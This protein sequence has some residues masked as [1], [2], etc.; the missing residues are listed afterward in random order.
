MSSFCLAAAQLDKSKYITIDEVKPGMDAYCLTVFEGTKI[1]KFGLEVLSVVHNFQ[2]GRDA[3]LVQGTDERFIHTG[4]VAGCSGS[5]VYIDGRLAGAL[6]FAWTYSKDPLYGVTPIE[7][8]LQV[9]QLSEEKQNLKKAI[10]EPGYA[11]DYSK[12]IDFDEVEKLL[13]APLYSK[14]NFHSSDAALP[15]PLV[16]SGLPGQVCEQ[17]SSWFEA[18]GLMVVP[19]LGTGA[20]TFDNEGSQDENLRLVP[21]ACLV[22]PLVTGDITMNAVGTVTD[23]QEQNV[24][25]FG[26][27]FLGYGAVNLP[28]ATGKVHT[29][30]SNIV[31]SFK[32]GSAGEIVGTLTQDEA[33]A[34]FGQIGEK[35][36]MIPLNITV[37]RYN[38]PIK[39]IYNCR[40]VDN[41]IYT[42]RLVQ[43]TLLGASLMLGTLPPYNTIEYKVEIELEN[44][45]SISFENVSAN[46]GPVE[47]LIDSSGAVALLMNNPFEK[48]NVRALDFNIN[49][50]ADNII[51][52]IWSVNLS[53]S[54]VKAGEELDI[55][56][57]VESFLKGK[58]EYQC[59]LKIPEQLK[60][61]RYNLMILGSRDYQAFIRQSS[62]YKF[63]YENLETLIDSIN[64][65]LSIRSDGLHCVL[66]L[67][68][69]GIAVQRAELPDLPA[70]K[71][72]VLQNPK[73]TLKAQPYMHWLEKSFT[74]G[75]IVFD[76]KAMSI[77]VEK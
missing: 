15:C 68:P 24:Y 1:E 35:P 55:S 19:G 38:D 39:R 51:S 17:V 10:P 48:V 28:M 37:E 71:A 4:P 62:P 18:L 2:P 25:G 50:T 29:V 63:T 14:Q 64:N 75:T 59:S 47:M 61:G 7:E 52:H 36:K 73:R 60:P 32:L 44:E 67:P 23:V 49:I 13:S 74:T 69:A 20:E 56:V 22:V 21:G 76:K 58:K 30:A 11:F 5:P 6:A 40:I 46:I 43:S 45:E 66:V 9:G 31:R 12:P 70:T 65:L 41:K 77:T 53:D 54:K 72:L 27:S 33:A 26:H 42:P 34:V 8:M 3:I 16:I 57:I